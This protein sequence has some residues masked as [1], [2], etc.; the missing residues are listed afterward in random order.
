M[1]LRHLISSRSRHSASYYRRHGVN[2]EDIAVAAWRKS[3]ASGFNNS[4]FEVARLRSDRIGVRD[5]KDSGSGP[6]LVFNQNEWQAFLTG[7]KAG[8]FDGI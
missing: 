6:V 5:T 8:E 7:A 2:P 4:C 3:S 1:Y